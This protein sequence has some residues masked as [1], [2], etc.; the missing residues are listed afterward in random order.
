MI[1]DA[2]VPGATTVGQS[3]LTDE[4][5]ADYDAGN[6]E[7]ADS[8]PSAEEL[9]NA[10]RVKDVSA[11]RDLGRRGRGDEEPNEETGAQQP[12]EDEAPPDD[13]RDL[14]DDQE[15]EVATGQ[16]P[17]LK[18]PPSAPIREARAKPAAGPAAAAVAGKKRT[19]L[20]AM[21]GAGAVALIVLALVV[22]KLAGGGGKSRV[23]V[24]V[25][26]DM[27]FTVT[28]NPPGKV[29]DGAKAIEL[30]PGE[31]ELD[32]RPASEGYKGQ[33]KKVSL[34]SGETK[35]V[36]IVFLR[37]EGGGTQPG[38]GAETPPPKVE[39][40]APGP[41]PVAKD[42]PGLKASPEPPKTEPRLEAPSGILKS[43]NAVITSAE[44]GVEIV[45][46]GHLAGKTPER[47]AEGSRPLEDVQGH[48]EEGR[49]RADELRDRRPQEAREGGR[50]R[51]SWSG[52]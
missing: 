42:D 47:D 18:P 3:P 31:Y 13:E 34:K 2:P 26:P 40:P 9:A 15:A 48:G 33:K 52:K 8:G 45:I 11:G 21:V 36:G 1:G 50:C 43:F 19:L 27:G 23:V 7:D 51:S 39:P 14:G 6:H 29:F 20:L 25:R 30:V 16:R 41:E 38:A 5:L 24:A 44:P 22:V 4:E 28:V 37:L 32:V 10:T 17:A 35:S 12:D 46:D 49:L